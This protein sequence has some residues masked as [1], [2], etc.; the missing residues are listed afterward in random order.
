M[1]FREL[2]PTGNETPMAVDT[3]PS[4]DEEGSFT[5][6]KRDDK[7]VKRKF[8]DDSLEK[9]NEPKKRLLNGD[10]TSSEESPST[11]FSDHSYCM[12]QQ[13]YSPPPIPDWETE[14]AMA[15]KLVS[16]NSVEIMSKQKI[17]EISPKKS[18]QP[19]SVRDNN[20]IE[21]LDQLSI[22]KHRDNQFKTKYFNRRDLVQEATILFEFLTKGID[23]EDINYLKQSYESLLANDTVHYWLNETHWVNHPDILLMNL[24]IIYLIINLLLR[25]L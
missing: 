11:V 19:L 21:L 16:S 23:V 2:T 22:Q 4:S 8:E 17:Q 18:K 15:D 13:V 14:L 10:K 3:L 24:V 20:K 25:D 12:P 9:P 5:K 6:Y 7:A 1:C